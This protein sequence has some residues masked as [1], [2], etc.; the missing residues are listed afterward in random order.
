ML[1]GLAACGGDSSTGPEPKAVATVAVSPASSLIGLGLT[2]TLIATPKDESGSTVTGVTVTWSSSNTQIATVNANGVVTAK[3]VGTVSITASAAGKDGTATVQ[4]TQTPPAALQLIFSTY[5]GGG[6]QDQVRDI[7]TDAAGNI[8]VTG[9][10]SSSDFPATAGTIDQS[11]NGT[12]DVYV[13]KLSPSGALL[14]ATYLGGPNYDRAY[15]IEVDAA[16]FIYI[17]GRAGAG[18]PVTAGAFQTTFQGSPD[19]P[20]YGPQDG[21]VCKLAPTGNSIV[22]CSYFGTSDPQ[23][24]RDIA[25]DGLGAMYLGSSSSSGTFPSTWFA[26]GYRSTPIGGLDGVVAKISPTGSQ[27]VWATYIGGTQDEAGEASIRVNSAGEAYALYTTGS[28]NAPTPN[29]FDRTLG[30]TRD[31][32]LVKLSA[33]GGSL[34]FGTFIGG[35]AGESIETHELV[36][37]PQGNPVISTG[38]SSTDFPTTPGA[39]QRIYGGSGGPTTGGGTNYGGDVFIAKV[40]ASG[41]QLLA[42]TYVG[43]PEG[44]G[45][46]GIGVD[47][48]GNIYISGATYSP[49]LIFMLGGRQPQLGG[50]ADL[51]AIKFAPDLSRILYGSYLGGT[52]QDYG[53]TATANGNGDF[54]IGGNILSTDWPVQ[55]AMQASSGGSL[56]GVIAKFR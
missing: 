37:D 36:L 25:V 33:S 42:S 54:I 27:V 17:A 19:D 4:V 47:A 16:G 18:F 44:E 29:G 49:G 24:V 21:F 35:S 22:F 48:Q 6:Q 12:Y 26:N 52:N 20:P 8:Y 30:G 28:S 31:A 51:F 11:F 40:S 34:L 23:I 2:E 10:T 56:D 50:D 1:L 3:A 14:W 38:T 53:R 15:A 39:Y 43:G 9:G 5:I 13:A 32:Y 46:E 41:S 55:S 45:A 7:A